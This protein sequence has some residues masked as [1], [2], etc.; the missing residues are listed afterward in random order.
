[1][2]RWLV[3]LVG[4]SIRFS[5]VSGM[6]LKAHTF[7]CSGRTRRGEYPRKRA[8]K[9]G[10]T[11]DNILNSFC[12]FVDGGETMRGIAIVLA[13]T[14]TSTSASAQLRSL[15]IATPH[16]IVL[17]VGSC[18]SSAF[19]PRI[20]PNHPQAGTYHNGVDLPALEG[21]PVRAVAPG[22]LLRIEHGGPGGLEVLI[23]H[24]GYVSVY[25]HLASVAPSLGQSVIAAGDEVGIVGHTGVSFGAHLFFALLE[26]GRAVDPKP[27]LG[28]PLCNGTTVHQRTPAEIL[29]AGEK[30]PPT[31]HYDLLRGLP[32]SRHDQARTTLVD[33]YCTPAVAMPST[34]DAGPNRISCTMLSW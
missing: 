5:Q 16:A 22:K 12:P 17:P 2:P 34:G 3:D 28:L 14:L 20:L 30:L 10:H 13:L 6:A 32:V 21:T 24:D 11:T 26:D 33:R 4:R 25:S 18:I 15:S 19:G 8:A 27:F 7:V 9:R 23:Q 31:R 1:V 29:A